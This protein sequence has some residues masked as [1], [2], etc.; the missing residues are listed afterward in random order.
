[1]FVHELLIAIYNA[2]YSCQMRWRNISGIFV[3]DFW[4]YKQDALIVHNVALFELRRDIAALWA[5][6]QD[7]IRRTHADF[8]SL[9][10]K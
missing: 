6:A 4:L 2:G 7:A 5:F 9:L 1:M 3:K 8:G 10:S